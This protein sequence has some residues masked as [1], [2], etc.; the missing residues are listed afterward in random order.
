MGV[1]LCSDR[2]GW[3]GVRW[4]RVRRNGRWEREAMGW[5]GVEVGW[6]WDGVGKVDEDAFVL[7][8]G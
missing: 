7:C 6:C 3:S 8:T 1:E 5:S 2:V 4:G